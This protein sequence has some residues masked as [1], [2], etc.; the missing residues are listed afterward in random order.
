[1]LTSIKLIGAH[2]KSPVSC[3]VQSSNVRLLS[4]IK[5]RLAISVANYFRWKVA[6]VFLFIFFF[7]MPWHQR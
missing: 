5:F 4:K 6:K 2:S 7:L 3:R 1:M